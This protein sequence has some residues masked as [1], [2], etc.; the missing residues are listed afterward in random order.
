M[1]EI[2]YTDIAPGAKAD[3][4]GINISEINQE[5][6]NANLLQ[7]EGNQSKNYATLELNQ[8]KLDGTYKGL[9]SN[10]IPFWGIQVSADEA[11]D[12]RY[13]FETP[14]TITRVFSNKHA[15]VGITL[16]FGSSEDFCNSLNIKWYNDAEIVSDKDFTPDEYCYY[17]EQNIELFNKVEI[18]FYSMNKPNRFLKVYAIDDGVLRRFKDRELEKVSVLEEISLIS[19][20]LPIDTLDFTLR[21]VGDTEFLFQKKQP[22]TVFHNDEF[23]G[24]FFIDSSER[25]S[26]FT[27]DVT[28]QN[29]IGILNAVKFYGG[30]YKDVTVQNI[31]SSILEN[32]GIEYELDEDLGAII[33]SGYIPI[34]SK[35]EALAQ[36]LFASGGVCTTARS[37]KMRIFKLGEE[38]KDIKSDSIFMGGKIS[39]SNIVTS[40]TVTG[41]D[42]VSS[43]ETSEVFKGELPIGTSYIE[44]SAPVDIDKT[45]SISSNAI[46]E[47]IYNNYCI[48]TV[49][50]AGDVS[51]S[52]YTYND[53]QTFKT[54][55]NTNIVSGVAENEIEVTDAT[56]VSSSNIDD[57]ASR[58]LSHYLKNKTLE[59]DIIINDEI[60]GDKVNLQT[61]WSGIQT[62]RIEQLEYDLRR[63]KIGKVVQRIG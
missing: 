50:T 4:S 22:L 35:R 32:E 29:Y 1:V 56:L 61:E 41:H 51:I 62:G 36:V 5:I 19:E 18:T 21:S 16:T 3:I 48:V 45:V 26:Y 55:R 59:C 2:L 47:A 46:I 39:V 28:A 14:I 9:T 17:C 40:I 12:G 52:A 8:W 7:I 49:S 27:Y 42:Y 37:K 25:T 24:N 20:E 13:F 54:L 53:N 11:T 58:V 31:V 6:S 60:C 23:T 63:K 57:V 43:L 15:S 10:V 38:A 44:F 33:L 30:I 34:C